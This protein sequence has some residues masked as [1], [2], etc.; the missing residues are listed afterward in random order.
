MHGYILHIYSYYK[1]SVQSCKE[2]TPTACTKMHA[3]KADGRETP[4]VVGQRVRGTQKVLM[5]WCICD[6]INQSI[7]AGLSIPLVYIYIH[8]ILNYI[9]SVI[10]VLDGFS[11]WNI[12]KPWFTS[13]H[14][15]SR[16]ASSLKRVAGAA[17]RCGTRW[18][19]QGNYPGDLIYSVIEGI[20]GW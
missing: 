17:V 2:K 12:L 18:T 6:V 8:I 1:A 20:Q 9:Y 4:R 19:R 5:L 16:S 3:C 14:S 15:C 10:T 7:E 13:C 11:L